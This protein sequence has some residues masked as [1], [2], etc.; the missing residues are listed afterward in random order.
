MTRYRVPA[1]LIGF[2][3]LYLTVMG[4]LTGTMVERMRFDARRSSVLSRLTK[5]EHQVRARLMDLERG[6]ARAGRW[7]AGS[8]GTLAEPGR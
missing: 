8:E 4:F 7:D 2:A 3:C 6:G 5:A 1:L